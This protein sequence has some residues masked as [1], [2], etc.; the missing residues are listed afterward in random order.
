MIENTNIEAAVRTESAVEFDTSLVLFFL[1]MELGQKAGVLSGENV[2][3]AGAFLA[4]MFAP[5]ALYGGAQGFG[6]W[7][8]GRTVIGGLGIAVGVGFG[9]AVGTLFPAIF[10]FLPFTLLIMAAMATVF[11]TFSSLVGLR[12]ED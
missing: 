12:R 4:V 11:F 2:L 10:E 8:L 3:M 1:A 5:Y 6:R 7:A 9:S